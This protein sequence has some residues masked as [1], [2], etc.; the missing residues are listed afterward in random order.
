MQVLV[1]RREQ[2]RELL[3]S[4]IYSPRWLSQVRR[5]KGKSAAR[6]DAGFAGRAPPSTLGGRD[7]SPHIAAS[8]SFQFHGHD[9]VLDAARPVRRLEAGG[10]LFNVGIW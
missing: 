6:Q 2:W 7:R 8:R 10:M 5:V 4:R 1:V 3:R 9:R